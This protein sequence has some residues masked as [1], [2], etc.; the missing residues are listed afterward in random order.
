MRSA[1][2]YLFAVK[3]RLTSF[4]KKLSPFRELS[5]FSMVL[6]KFFTETSFNILKQAKRFVATASF[7]TDNIGLLKAMDKGT[8][9]FPHGTVRHLGQRVSFYC[10][11]LE[12]L[13]VPLDAIDQY[14]E[15]LT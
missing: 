8:I 9:F 15:K 5:L 10:V 2:E 11:C 3:L 13:L 4:M 12:R 1:F 7:D 6:T 14:I